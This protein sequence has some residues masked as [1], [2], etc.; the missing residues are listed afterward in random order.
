MGDPGFL[1]TT[2][3]WT[4]PG[5]ELTPGDTKVIEV[6]ASWDVEAGSSA[7]D[8]TGGLATH[9]Y[10]PETHVSI[11]QLSINFRKD[12]SGS[13]SNS[14]SFTIPYGNKEGATLSIYG[15]ADAAV[16]GGRVD[17]KYIYFCPTATPTPT[18]TETPTA[19]ST[20]TETS[21]PTFTATTCP[22]LTE[23]EKYEAIIDLYLASDFAL[24]G[25]S[26]MKINIFSWI[27]D[28]FDPYVCGSYQAAVL[29]MLDKLK[30]SD[31]PCERELLAKW[32]YGPIQ[33]WWGFHQAVV[34]YPW[35]T[36][37]EETGTVLDP[38]IEQK[39][40]IYT[41]KNWA[42]YFSGPAFAPLVD[43]SFT[44]EERTGAGFRGVGPSS[45]YAK[46]GNYPM[47]GGDYSAAGNELNLTP[48][49]NEIIKALP[50]DKKDIFR[51]MSKKTQKDYLEIKLAR[52]EQANRVIADC[53][54]KLYLVNAEGARSGISGDTIYNQL[55]NVR[56]MALPL[57]D[58][59]IVTEMIYPQGAGYTLVF[60]GTGDGQGEVLIGETFTLDE[61]V[62][63]LQK[64]SFAVEEAT[65]YQV[66][67]DRLGAPLL[68]SGGSLEPEVITELSEEWVNALPELEGP[69]PI[70][71]VSAPANSGGSSGSG[72][73]LF[74]RFSRWQPALPGVIF[75]FV[76]GAAGLLA[77][78]VLLINK[79]A[80]RNQVAA[81]P[82]RNPPAV[83]WILLAGLFAIASEFAFMGGVGLLNNL[84]G[85]D[86]VEPAEATEATLA[87]YVVVTATSPL[88]IEVS[89]PATPLPA[90][91]EVQATITPQPL[92]P[93]ATDEVQPLEPFSNETGFFDDFSARTFGWLE[94]DEARRIVQYEDGAY[95]F[96]MY[97]RDD[98]DVVDLPV[99][100]SP[101]EIAFDVQGVEGMD[102]GTFGVFCQYQ[103]QSNYYYAEFD[104]LEGSYIIAQSLDGEYVPLTIP[105]AEGEYWLVSEALKPASQKNHIE[106]ECSL[107]S[108]SVEANGELVDQ[109]F[110]EKPIAQAGSASLFVY[111]YEFAGD[112]G[113]K[114]FFD[115]LEAYPAIP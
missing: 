18:E 32:D 10:F 1:S 15:F 48:E 31:N 22:A 7:G 2:H 41:I 102:D 103:D 4:Y 11:T 86:G 91:I 67:T 110:V 55:P 99:E 114:V 37:W 87:P 88:S 104:L 101:E 44:E 106:L 30:F 93:V 57:Q 97:A 92:L 56:F 27:D 66:A 80:R 62:S 28:V 50:Q 54:L 85:E 98:F 73:S 61:G 75:L 69:E 29:R 9:F 21:T 94:I 14:A 77:F 63:S 60:E 84:T 47:F 107:D 100:F 8:S 43:N 71:R 20:A 81:A 23:E 79:L 42:M 64:Y 74:E 112:E 109:V 26:G 49:E 39:P 59:T 40:N 6:G 65:V 16:G 108:I 78:A 33:A 72:D 13:I 35:A 58:G 111:T 36:A 17:F 46:P 83:Q 68:W 53:P 82:P 25:H 70:N 24:P 105:N 90:T 52:V 38:W 3:T 76:V 34:L 95:S 5:T 96:Q 115:N 45:V 19:T 51:R 89:P 113:Y 12:P